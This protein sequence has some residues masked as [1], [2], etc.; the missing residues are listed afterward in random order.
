MDEFELG[1]GT[2]VVY[3]WLVGLRDEEPAQLWAD[4]DEN[5]KLCF[6][7]A[8]LMNNDRAK[9]GRREARAAA[10]VSGDHKWFGQMLE[11]LTEQWRHV[12]RDL[13]YEPAII[14]ASDLVG[15][16]MELVMVTSDEFAGDYPAGARIPAHS[17]ITH[18]V[19]REWKIAATSRRLPL[20]GWPPTEQV[21]EGLLG[22]TE[23]R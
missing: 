17:F 19:G 11:D 6:A 13:N 16:D 22:S 9:P 23:S 1:G 7:Q 10:L 3:R 15:P 21:I 12:Y 5:L 14:A 8:W 2:P 20:P 4:L 18:Y